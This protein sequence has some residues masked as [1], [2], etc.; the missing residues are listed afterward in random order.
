MSA[1]S[2]EVAKLTDEHKLADLREQIAEGDRD[3]AGGRLLP[4]EEVFAG[5]RKKLA[6]EFPT[7]GTRRADS[8]DV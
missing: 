1:T 8:Q 6:N 2:R 3:I 4:A 7:H 5:L